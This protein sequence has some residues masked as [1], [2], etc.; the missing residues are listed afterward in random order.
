MHRLAVAFLF[1]LIPRFLPSILRFIRLVWRLTFD[2]RVHLALRALVPLALLYILSPL[3]LLKDTV[4]ILGRFDDLVVLALAVLL[5]TK[6]APRHVVEEHLG[7]RPIT[8]RPEDKDP[9]QVV[10]GTGRIVDEE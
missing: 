3:D 6:L 5:L 2:K 1:M 9:S 10:D 8:D 4:P 7:N